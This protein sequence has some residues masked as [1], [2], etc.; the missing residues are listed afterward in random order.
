M[1]RSG[2]SYQ[3]PFTT[4]AV[5]TGTYTAAPWEL[6]R[7]DATSAGFTVTLPAAATA[8]QQ[9]AVKLLATSGTNTV[10]VA[11]A[12]SDTINN[13]ATSITLTLT[14]EAVVFTSNGAGVW[15]VAQGRLTLTS[16]NT[17]TATLTNKRV[18]A[19]VTS[20]ASSATPTP[21]ADT[22]DQYQLTALAAAAT[23]AAPTGT[24]TDGQPL[25]I[26]IKDN[27]TARTLAWNAIYRAV[28][29]TLPTTTVVSKM[30]YVGM[31][32][33]AAAVK[34]DVLAVATEA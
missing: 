17:A 11:R 18:T 3:T 19:R 27:G 4:T 22:D 13:A 10:T 9:V 26:Q 8:G 34:F 16:L 25:I 29:V 28:G 5:K 20:T 14:D 32:Y 33:N 1:G 12:G 2:A 6:V 21:N 15:T 23:F 31:R 7:C 24:P 30:L